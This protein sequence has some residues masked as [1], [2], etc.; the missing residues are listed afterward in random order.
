MVANRKVTGRAS[1]VPAGLAAGV[2][3]AMGITLLTSLLVAYLVSGEFI[4]QDK[5]GY[6]AIAVLL[7]S[8]GIGARLAITKI[9]KMPIQIAA[10]C[11]LL[12]YIVLL[13]MTAL[14]F[15][16]QFDGMGVTLVV[17]LL[18][19]GAGGI[20]TSGKPKRQKR[21]YHKF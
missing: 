10:L 17:V 16:G 4:E 2:I 11:G 6:G 8:S 18:G 5:I 1:S 9:K 21:K 3:T 7:L 20:M 12:F 15:G 14:F 13:L 19:S